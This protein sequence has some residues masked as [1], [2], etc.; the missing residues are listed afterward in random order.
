MTLFVQFDQRNINRWF[1]KPPGSLL[2]RHQQ[3]MCQQYY[4][5]YHQPKFILEAGLTK[6]ISVLAGTASM[7]QHLDL[8]MLLAAEKNHKEAAAML[9]SLLAA[10]APHSM[11]L[12]LV[13]HLLDFCKPG[14]QQK[15]IKDLVQ[16]TE[17][18]SNIII[19]GF[20]PSGL[21]PCQAK[22]TKHPVW[23]HSVY[24]PI[25]RIIRQLAALNCISIKYTF[26]LPLFPWHIPEHPPANAI[27]KGLQS[28]LCFW[29]C[30]YMIRATVSKPDRIKPFN[31][32]ALSYLQRN[33]IGLKPV[34][35]QK[36]EDKTCASYES[37][38]N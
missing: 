27:Y 23:Q 10:C 36:T 31:M 9:K 24:T 5:K 35:R 7:K 34:A 21:W 28:R 3:A 11:Q 8:S 16:V 18:G 26:H 20:N 6:K 15:M 17:Y 32:A 1:T 13:H 22:I 37:D 2:L 38:K 30:Y 4:Q 29:S 14:L 33:G 25:Y 12:T 19:L